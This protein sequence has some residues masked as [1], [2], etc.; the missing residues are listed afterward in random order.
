MKIYLS[1]LFLL[2]CL[3]ISGGCTSNKYQQL[4]NDMQEYLDTNGQTCLTYVENDSNIIGR[5]KENYK[6]RHRVMQQTLDEFKE[7]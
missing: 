5:D 4:I 6:A 7:K 3:L 1:S 2:I